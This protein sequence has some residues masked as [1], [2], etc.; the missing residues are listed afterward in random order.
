MGQIEMVSQWMR[1]VAEKLG[2][3][4]AEVQWSLG[5]T[6]GDGACFQGTWS[7]DDLIPMARRVLNKKDY[8]VMRRVLKKGWGVGFSIKHSGHYYHYNSYDLNEEWGYDPDGKKY[9]PR[10][11]EVLTTFFKNIHEDIRD[12]GKQMAADGYKILEAGSPMWWRIK[13]VQVPVRFKEGSPRN[14]DDREYV[15]RHRFGRFA[16]TVKL[17]EDTDWEAFGDLETLADIVK[18]NQVYC[19]VTVKVK[20]RA[21]GGTWGQASLWGIGDGLD[22]QYTTGEVVSELVDEAISEARK[23]LD[24]MG[25]PHRLSQKVEVPA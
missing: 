23:N 21:S 4:R 13:K 16:I 3:V 25:I 6:Q 17:V 19:G 24:Q 20:D 14:G 12:V 11:E 8:Q 15:M 10:Q 9:T 18:G 5:Y 1:H 2:Y 7:D 22:L